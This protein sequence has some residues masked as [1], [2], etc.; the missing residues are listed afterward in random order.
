MMPKIS[1]FF[2]QRVRHCILQLFIRRNHFV[3]LSI[4]GRGGGGGEGVKPG[5]VIT[6]FTT[7]GRFSFSLNLGNAV[8]ETQFSLPHFYCLHNGLFVKTNLQIF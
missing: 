4:R 8:S 7:E 2:A 6:C 3:F 5:A 1:L